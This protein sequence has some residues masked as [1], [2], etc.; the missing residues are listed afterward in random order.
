MNVFVLPSPIIDATSPV[1]ISLPFVFWVFKILFLI[2]FAIY[3][4]YALVII[5]QISLMSR[6]V[7]TGFQG[8]LKL[9][10]AIHFFAAVGIWLLA[11]M[12]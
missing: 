9:L 7:T 1:L 8:V 4:I 5:R 6:S 10:A 12:A 11:L 2:A 3:V